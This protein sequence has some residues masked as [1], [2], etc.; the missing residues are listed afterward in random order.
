MRSKIYLGKIAY[1]SG[2]KI[3]RVTI[4]LCLEQVTKLSINYDTLQ[5]E[6]TIYK[7]WHKYHLNDSRAGTKLQTDAIENWINAGNKY[8]YT[9]AC[10]YLKSIDLYLD[11]SYKYGTAWLVQ[12]MPDEVIEDIKQIISNNQK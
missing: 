5:S 7:Y 1:T 10:E 9:A 11:R 8:D 12:I 3:N 6:F 4:D 2:K